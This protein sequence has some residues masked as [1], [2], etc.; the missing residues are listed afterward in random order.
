[1]DH[2]TATAQA[3]SRV[4]ASLR[5]GIVSGMRW[6]L[7]LS[8]LSLPLGYATT[9]LLARVSPEA[10]GTYGL[11]TV[12]ISLTSV[13]FFLGGNAVSIKFFPEL[14]PDKRLA[15]LIS[16]SLIIVAATLPY[17]IAGSLWPSA[18]RY[19]LGT[20][21][22]APFQV[23]ILWLAP[24]YVGYSLVLSALKGM[25]EI[26]WAQILARMVTV[27]S[28]AIYAT[29]FSARRQL[30]ATY[31]TQL[32]W[33]VYLGLALLATALAIRQVTVLNNW[34][35]PGSNVCFFLPDGF[36]SFTLGLQAS[37]VLGFLSTRLDYILILNAGGLGVLGRYVALMTLVSAASVF[38]TFI[39]DSFLP[40]LTT[41]LALGDFDACRHTTEVYLRIML[42]CSLAAA[43]L[44]LFFAHPLV[45]LLGGR[46]QSL[47]G[48]T[49]I[50]VPFVA[51][52]VV[53]WFIGTLLSA[54]GQ[55]HQDA[56]AK[57]LRTAVFCT[58]FWILWTRFNLLGAVCAWAL[59]E[60]CYQGVGLCLLLR[61][62]PFKLSLLK[63]YVPFLIVTFSA[64]LG[65][66]LFGNHGLILSSAG[67]LASI[68][69]FGLMA[70]FTLREAGALIRLVV[71]R[72]STL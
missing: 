63:T 43:C 35:W 42:P 23:L 7:W 37:S 55:P 44:V 66:R 70:K 50:A 18:L 12:Y 38:A 56:V 9:V 52:Q 62:I 30:L 1:M 26:K 47:V 39:L 61:K 3:R 41:T 24:I 46:Y 27:G 4:P 68:L 71:V 14:S 5:V 19:L 57:T 15:F 48:L 6:T 21:A 20:G 34:K 36:W 22:G 53:N 33:G 13:F 10:I 60:V 72:G 16:Y 32:I 54:I 51:V 58:S 65:A 45:R 28:F 8:M 59:G 11:L 69:C 29:L 49:L 67:W 31:Y 2:P 64:A 40:S 17:Q 25:M